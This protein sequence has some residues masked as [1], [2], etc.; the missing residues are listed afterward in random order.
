MSSLTNH[1]HPLSTEGAAIWRLSSSSTFE[2]T[3]KARFGSV[4]V[5]G[6]IG[7]VKGLVRI[8][9]DEQIRMSVTIDTAGLLFDGTQRDA[10]LLSHRLPGLRRTASFDSHRPR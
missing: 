8:D 6:S 7:L 5:A 10:R 9:P 4:R 2:V 3:V 1:D